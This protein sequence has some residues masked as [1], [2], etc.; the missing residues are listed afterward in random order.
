M[1]L[2][3]TINIAAAVYYFSLQNKLEATRLPS[4]LIEGERFPVF[5]GI[6]L[7]GGKWES[8]D[9]PCR[10]IRITDDNCPHCKR[11]A[12]SYESIVAAAQKSACEIIEISPRSGGMAYNPRADV[13]Q[14]RF[15]STNI[16]A[17]LYPFVTP[18]TIILNKDWSVVMTRRGA[19]D[20]TSLSRAVAMLDMFRGG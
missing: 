16:G 8:R 19:F 10:V 15:L 11:D 6:D 20:E 14:L 17:V 18:Q 3:A 7:E 12:P 1:V 5:S 13:V 2:V 4:R 9:A